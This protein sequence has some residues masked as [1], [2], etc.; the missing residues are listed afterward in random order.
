MAVVR[1]RS[2]S[3]SQVVKSAIKSYID[4]KDTEEHTTERL[5]LRTAGRPISIPGD[6]GCW[7]VT[8]APY[9]TLGVAGMVFGGPGDNSNAE[10]SYM[11]PMGVLLADIEKK[12]KCRA[13]L[14]PVADE[15]F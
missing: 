10:W 15:E 14:L 4:M 11:T 13:Q 9:L 3:I 8:T 5:L 6:L 2:G 7:V 12:L 1:S